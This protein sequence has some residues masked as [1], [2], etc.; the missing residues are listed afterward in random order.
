MLMVIGEDY[1]GVR[2]E[3]DIN[4]HAPVLPAP[5]PLS[6]RSSAKDKKNK[7]VTRLRSHFCNNNWNHFGYC[8]ATVLCVLQ[9]LA[10][11]ITYISCLVMMTVKS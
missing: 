2:Y 11:Q 7:E 4:V 3:S 5:L 9:V 10:W 6:P 8:S 1:T